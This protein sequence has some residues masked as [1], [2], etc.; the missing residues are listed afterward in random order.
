MIINPHRYCS[1]LYN[2]L[3]QVAHAESRLAAA[4]AD[5][6]T[7]LKKEGKTSDYCFGECRFVPRER[8]EIWC[9]E[10]RDETREEELTRYRSMLAR[11][12]K[13][14]KKADDDQD[15]DDSDDSDDGVDE[16]DDTPTEPT[17]AEKKKRK[18][19]EAER[20]RREAEGDDDEE[21]AA[22]RFAARDKATAAAIIAAGRKRRGEP[23]PRPSSER[24]GVTNPSS[25]TVVPFAPAPTNPTA[26]AIVNAGR[27][28]RGLPPLEDD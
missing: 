6:K 11:M 7:A 5:Y 12:K 17:D 27:K 9:E 15:D 14:S 3:E 20:K 2:A 13:A 28:A 25:Q 8:A 23:A 21:A 19:K 18:A 1:P 4:R 10:A 26:R 22:A 24:Q 16:G